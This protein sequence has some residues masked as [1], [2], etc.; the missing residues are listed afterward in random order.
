MKL[1]R[2]FPLAALGLILLAVIT[3]CVSRGQVTLLLI[4]GGVAAA[5][6][7]VTEGPR[8]LV[9]PRPV[10]HIL[11]LAASAAA[12]FDVTAHPHDAE[13]VL[14]RFTIWVALI[15]LYERKTHADWAQLMWL[16]L[17]LMVAA[18]L[19]SR[20]LL[21]GAALLVY[22]ALG[23]FVLVLHQLYA[24]YEK[25][26][27]ERR[28]QAPAEAR[29]VPGVQPVVGRAA[30]VQLAG[31]VAALALAGLV[32]G[33]LVFIAYPR[34]VGM[35][36]MR[37]L[38][39]APQRNQAGAVEQVRLTAGSRITDS[40]A[41]V[42]QVRMLDHQD[43]GI[44]FGPP[45]Y[46]RGSALDVYDE[47]SFTWRKSDTPPQYLREATSGPTGLTSLGV[48][49]GDVGR[50]AAEETYTLEVAPL[51]ALGPTVF[52]MSTPLAVSTGSERRIVF[53]QKLRTMTMDGE[54]TSP[55]RVR[56]TPS[57]SPETL[58]A[59]SG[60]A[61]AA[62]SVQ[63]YLDPRVQK[64]AVELLRS[65]GL[66][67][68]APENYPERGRYWARAARVFEEYLRSDFRYTLD[69]SD[70][71]IE[72]DPIVGFL[73][74]FRRG[75]CEY[76]AS[77]MTALCQSIDIEARLV[78]G[79][80]AAEYEGDGFY[81]V[82]ESNA[83]AWVEV[84][85]S[86]FG[87]EEFDPSPPSVLDEASMA[88]RQ[89]V[90][91]VYEFF[92]VG[93]IENIVQFDESAQADVQR[94]LGLDSLQWMESTMTAVSEWLRTFIRRFGFAGTLQIAVIAAAGVVGLLVIVQLVRRMKR[95][96]RTL[97]LEHM[98]R[99]DARR[100]LRQLAFYLDMLDVLR[101]GGLAKPLW[102]PPLQFAEVV[103]AERPE[104]APDV[105]DL[106]TRF[107]A[108]RYGQREITPEQVEDARATVKKMAAALGVRV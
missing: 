26:R 101:R 48:F 10:S 64:L 32:L 4:A 69:L 24:A 33:A 19:Q 1:L 92:E 11:M 93:W 71:E 57:P 56:I 9:L 2:S 61:A 13:G 27:E 85:T 20:D 30:G 79:F 12:L 87:W 83:H 15:K 55:Y 42:M 89:G 82:R 7:Y 103:R 41:P 51:A 67:T 29:L 53:D 45:M 100:L 18:V 44:D 98:A 6:W 50:P 63:R 52:A 22:S 86:F 62:G 39:Q 38:L 34:G 46:L 60:G 36:M 65:E 25:A 37:G 78:T 49:E 95:I 106:S 75:H 72:G 58:V 73:F 84:R 80:V 35:G 76:F 107:Y 14:G 68:R 8:G 81:M 31:T 77:A 104:I 21:V 105:R 47:R 54:Q 108:V 16:S 28:T 91:S 102:Q 99:R 40:R 3:F 59:L 97:H 5:S 88:R 94:S 90:G 23:V 17:I 70:V 66:A 74:D 96:R 43:R